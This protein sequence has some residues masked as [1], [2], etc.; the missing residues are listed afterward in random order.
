[1]L[2]VFVDDLA[3]EVADFVVGAGVWC[4]GSHSV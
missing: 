4:G 1:L 2:D 3:Q